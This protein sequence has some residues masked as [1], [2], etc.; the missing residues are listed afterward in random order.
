MTFKPASF[1]SALAFPSRS[2]EQLATQI[3]QQQKILQTLRAV[4]PET[5]SQHLHHCVIND[6]KLMIYT[7]SAAWASQLR[8]YDKA[9]LAAIAPL[10]TQSVSIVQLKLVIEQV[11]PNRADR[12]TAII[13]ALEKLEAIRDFCR[14]DPDNELTAALLKLTK[15]L[16]DL[17]ANRHPD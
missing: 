13:P 10:T 16:E 3:K 6:K 14:A 15:T 9:L 12:E 8:F 5:L 2:I 11:G 17:G 4:L 7:D 1:K